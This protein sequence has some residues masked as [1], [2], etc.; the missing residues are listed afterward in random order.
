MDRT[1][2]EQGYHSA[3]KVAAERLMARIASGEADME[4]QA[5]ALLTNAWATDFRAT[6][7]GNI[8]H[9]RAHATYRALHISETA[10]ERGIA[11]MLQE[12][13]LAREQL[14]VPWIWPEPKTA[15]A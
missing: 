14:G 15:E 3:V 8:E 12:T 13:R 11:M 4:V 5:A 6:L 2:W 1:A 9:A 10:W 7:N